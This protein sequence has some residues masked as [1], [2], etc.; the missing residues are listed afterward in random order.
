MILLLF[1]IFSYLLKLV[2]K[3]L[4]L[5]NFLKQ[6]NWR[7]IKPKLLLLLKKMKIKVLIHEDEK[8]GYWAEVPS[9]PG[10]YTQA[11]TLEELIPNVYEAVD[12]YLKVQ[13]E[14]SEINVKTRLYGKNKKR[15]KVLEMIV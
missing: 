14:E 8:K 4:N 5:V 15:Y 6:F 3:I 2:K 10:C 13:E 7:K 1:S 9:L 12:G 11:D